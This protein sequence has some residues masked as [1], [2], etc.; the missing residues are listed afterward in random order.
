VPRISYFYGIIISMP[1]NDHDPPHFH[2]RYAEHKGRVV[3]ETGDVLPGA[4]LPRRALRLVEEWRAAHIH[5]LLAA[6]SAVR[7]GRQPG[8]IDPLP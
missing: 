1:A 4:D 3:I 8:T 5:E 7:D 2:I 6:W